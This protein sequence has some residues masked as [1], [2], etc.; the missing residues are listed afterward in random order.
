[1]FSKFLATDQVYTLF[2]DDKDTFVKFRV[3]IIV[4]NCSF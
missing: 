2:D 1:M 4:I 3:Y